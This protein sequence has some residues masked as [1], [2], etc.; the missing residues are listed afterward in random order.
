MFISDVKSELLGYIASDRIIELFTRAKKILSSKTYTSHFL[1]QEG[2]WRSNERQAGQGILTPDY[3][4]MTRNQIKYA[5]TSIVEELE[6]SD[7]NLGNGNKNIIQGAII[8]VSGDF[9]LGD[10]YG[11]AN[12]S[13]NFSRRN[14]SET[15]LRTIDDTWYDDFASFLEKGPSRRGNRCKDLSVYFFE[16]ADWMKGKGHHFI[17]DASAVRTKAELCEAER[18]DQ[19]EAFDFGEALLVLV[20]S[21]LD[22]QDATG[23][24]KKKFDK[25]VDA[26]AGEKEMKAY[27]VAV[28]KKYDKKHAIQQEIVEI[29]DTYK[30]KSKHFKSMGLTYLQRSI[31]EMGVK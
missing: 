9:R 20:E 2:R 22:A 30:S 28:Q 16:V 12:S 23:G 14:S 24:L 17:E 10:D 5:L 26:K 3:A 21:M 13:N 31:K 8:N 7:L 15:N 27:L 25:A 29:L 1:G 4:N 11:I 6:P 18:I 19:K